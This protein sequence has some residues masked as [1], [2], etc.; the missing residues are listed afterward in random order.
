MYLR[1]IKYSLWPVHKIMLLKHTLPL[2]NFLAYTENKW[3]K[4]FY[5][6]RVIVSIS[7]YIV[8]YSHHAH[9]H[10]TSLFSK[11][12]YITYTQKDMVHTAKYI[13]IYILDDSHLEAENFVLKI[14]PEFLKNYKLGSVRTRDWNQVILI[15]GAEIFLSHVTEFLQSYWDQWFVSPYS[16]RPQ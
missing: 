1:W 4:N 14:W 10:G 8:F 12:F 16:K 2:S 15:S 6:I 3:F 11:Y 5:W 9:V 7:Y 13:Y